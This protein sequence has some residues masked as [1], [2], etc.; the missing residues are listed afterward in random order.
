MKRP[1]AFRRIAAREYDEAADWYDCKQ[2][3]L[4]TEFVF[5]VRRVLQLIAEQP[6][7]YAEVEG[8]VREALVH[9]FPYCIYFRV[10]R[11]AS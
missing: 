5:E 8:G 1:I 2:S 4:R 7:R 3:G 6:D 11:D 10:R 9:R